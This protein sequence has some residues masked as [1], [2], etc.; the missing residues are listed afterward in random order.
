[1]ELPNA[2]ADRPLAGE[3]HRTTFVNYLRIAFRGGGF[4]GWERH[5]NRPEKELQFLTE[6]L[7]PI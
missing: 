3:P 6:S 2:A 4:P 7:L 5:R 1:M